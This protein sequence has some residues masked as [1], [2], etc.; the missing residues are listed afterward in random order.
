MEE[1]DSPQCAVP[2]PSSSQH[3]MAVPPDEV[4][5]L[6]EVREENSPSDEA[7]D[8]RDNG[9]R[10]EVDEGDGDSENPRQ[11][12]SSERKDRFFA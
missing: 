5:M 1:A 9:E 11:A 2:G 4:D 12:S 10:A 7:D 3:V 6:M 8:S